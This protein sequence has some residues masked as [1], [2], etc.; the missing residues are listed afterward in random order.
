MKRRNM[1]K[2]MMTLLAMTAARTAAAMTEAEIRMVAERVIQI[3]K[4]K[5]LNKTDMMT[6]KT[7]EAQAEAM[8][9]AIKA[10]D[11]A[12]QERI[13]REIVAQPTTRTK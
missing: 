13:V 2:L 7:T 3:I 4:E 10:G 12:A 6:V 1:T 5:R 11:R 9:A 8:L